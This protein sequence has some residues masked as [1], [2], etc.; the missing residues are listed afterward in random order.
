[1]KRALFLLTAAVPVLPFLEMV[2]DF[3]MR[4]RKPLLRRPP[5]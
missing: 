4:G 2:V 1:M 5:R 3:A